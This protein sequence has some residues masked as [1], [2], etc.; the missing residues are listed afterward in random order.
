MCRGRSGFIPVEVGLKQQKTATATTTITTT[1]TMNPTNI[2]LI[3][4]LLKWVYF[5]LIFF[6]IAYSLA[7]KER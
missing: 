1:T 7:V 5:A 6:F 4:V 2:H 3:S